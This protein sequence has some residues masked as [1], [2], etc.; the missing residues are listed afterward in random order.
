[1][2]STV[3]ISNKISE[4]TFNDI[5]N[6]GAKIKTYDN[7]SYIFIGYGIDRDNLICID[8]NNMYNG[9]QN[10]IIKKNNIKYVTHKSH[11]EDS[12]RFIYV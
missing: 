4:L 8:E 10:F 12:R 6:P 9:S 11:N 7:K 3:S 1:M 2:G 5:L